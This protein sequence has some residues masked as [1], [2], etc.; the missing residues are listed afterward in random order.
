MKTYKQL[1]TELEK[2][3]DQTDPAC[4]MAFTDPDWRD[5][6][7]NYVDY[8]GV[9]NVYRNGNGINIVC[10]DNGTLTW[11]DVRIKLY[12]CCANDLNA[13][14]NITIGYGSS[15]NSSYLIDYND[16]PVE[17]R[18]VIDCVVLPEDTIWNI[19]LET[20]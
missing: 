5:E 19:H 10:S 4:I 12:Q 11:E 8:S 13:I 2:F 14:A 15:P 16:E 1:I 7:A 18:R 17:S 20:L 3:E 9:Y 6:G